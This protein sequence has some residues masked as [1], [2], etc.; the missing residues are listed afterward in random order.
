MVWFY[1]R[2][3]TDVL[4]NLIVALTL[5]IMV[6]CIKDIFFIDNLS[7]VS[8][9]IREAITAF[10]M[11]VIPLYNALL[12]ELCYPGKLKII[13]IVHQEIPF[14]ILPI[15]LIFTGESIIF[16]ICIVLSGIYVF[17][18]IFWTSITIPHYYR[19]LKENCP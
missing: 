14:V 9:G 13:D 1:W 11:T 4:S 6:Q 15:L 10:S 5:M 2:K 12:T 8:T 17:Y 18:F 16:N 3:K 19:K 7:N